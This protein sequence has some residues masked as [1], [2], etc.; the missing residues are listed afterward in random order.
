MALSLLDARQMAADRRSHA[1]LL[2]VGFHLRHH[3]VHLELV[4]RLRSGQAGRPLVVDALWGAGGADIPR[5]VWQMDPELAGLGSLGGLGVH[6]VDL[7][8]WIAD[9]DVVEVVAMDDG[10]WEGHPVEFLTSALLRFAEAAS[11]I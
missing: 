1:R 6:L 4:R 2:G 8:L 10:T 5:D 11:A 3:P 7:L 9:D